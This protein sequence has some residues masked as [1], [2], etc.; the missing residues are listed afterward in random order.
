LDTFNHKDSTTILSEMERAM[1]FATQELVTLQPG[2]ERVREKLYLASN[3]QTTRE[4][5]IAYSLFGIFNVA[6]PVIYGEGNQAV[7]HLMEHVLMGSGDVTI[8]AWTGT[9]GSYNSCLPMDLTVYNQIVP[10]H[11]PQ[12]IDVVNMNSMVAT[13]R[14]SLLDLSPAVILHGRLNDFPSPSIAASRLRLPGIS[15]RLT[16]LVHTT[17][18]DPVTNL[19]VYHGTTSVFGDVEIRT[20]DDLTRMMKGLF[21]VHPWIRLLLDQEFLDGAAVL[22]KTMQALQF[23]ARLRQPFGA[24]LFEPL[25]H[26]EHKRVAADSLIIARVREEAS[27]TE[28]MDGIRMINIQ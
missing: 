10:P 27:L 17:D 15:C 2:L 24:L 1:S 13:L 20:I 22:D 25:S 6:I 11:I 18:R 7:G 21:L 23:V 8:L 14:S 26:V 3:R 12:P 19:H 5:D 9:S 16:Q 28:L 4:E